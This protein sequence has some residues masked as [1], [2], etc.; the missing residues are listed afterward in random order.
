M[1]ADAT[2]HGL[3][4]AMSQLPVSQCFYEMTR[5]GYSIAS[6]VAAM[7]R[8]LESMLTV[9][10]YVAAILAS[11][12]FNNRLIEVWNG[13]A[14]EAYFVNARGEIMQRFPSTECALGIINDGSYR[15][16][17]TAFQW[18][19]PGELIIYSDGLLDVTNASGELYGNE[20]LFQA[21]E[22]GRQ[23]SWFS[24]L[25]QHIQAYYDQKAS[26]DDISLLTVHCDVRAE[27]LKAVNG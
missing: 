5:K 24:S 16:Q 10:R 3:S 12:D 14:P 7:N 23:G 20:R 18:E 1:V 8:K 11:V 6:I 27:G 19:E 13:A 9:E 15:L 2:G 22:A 26:F 4:A 25:K 21:L 17:T